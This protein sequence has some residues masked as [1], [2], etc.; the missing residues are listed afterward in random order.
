MI[1]PTEFIMAAVGTVLALQGWILSN[2]ISQ[3]KDIAVIKRVLGL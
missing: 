3:G 1:I 2:Q